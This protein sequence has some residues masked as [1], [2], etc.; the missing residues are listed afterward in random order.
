[1]TYFCMSWRTFW[2]HDILLTLSRIFY[3]MSYF[4]NLWRRFWQHNIHFDPVGTDPN[5]G[6][7]A[8]SNSTKIW[9]RV[10]RRILRKF[11]NFE[12]KN[13][14]PF[15]LWH[16]SIFLLCHDVL[17][18]IIDVMKYVLT[19]WHTFDVIMYLLYCL[20][21]WHTFDGNKTSHK[22]QINNKIFLKQKRIRNLDMTNSL[23][24]WDN[25][26]TS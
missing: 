13:L 10:L 4:R 26:L 16:H 12:E 18:D 21:S 9:N 25:I 2:R 11:L 15:I 17:F 1:M 24:S 19:L 3:I 23:T 14:N 5:F 20:T 22:S 8:P 7:Y 6:R